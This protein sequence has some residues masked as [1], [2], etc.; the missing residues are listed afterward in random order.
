MSDPINKT[1]E[2]IEAISLEVVTI[3]GADISAM[4]KILNLLCDMEEDAE[5]IG[6]PVFSDLIYGLKN[7]LEKAIMGETDDFE[8]FELGVEHLGSIHRCIRNQEKYKDDISDILDKL[9]FKCS[10][11]EQEEKCSQQDRPKFESDTED[12]NVSAEES[13]AE[14]N[15]KIEI[16]EDIKHPDQDMDEEDREILSGFVMESLE[17]LEAVEVSMMDLEQDPGDIETI[18]SIFR[19]FHTIKGVSAFL[20][21]DRINMLAHRSENLLDKARSSEIRID[22]TVIDI[23]LESVDL[24]KKLIEGVQQGM[25]NGVSLDIGLDITSLVDRIEKIQVEADQ[26]ADKPLGEILI[27]KGE[28]TPEELANALES[29]K[30]EPVKKIGQIL[31]QEKSVDPKSVVAALRNQK[32]TGK[33]HID[34][35]VKVDTK[36]LDNLVDLTGELVIAQSMLRQNRTILATRDQQLM[37]NLGQ[38]TQ[39]TTGLQTTAMSM[40]MVPIKNTFQKMV[41][42]VRDLAKN[43]GKEVNLKMSGKDTEIDRNVVDELYEPMVHMIRNSVDHGIETP[44]ERKKAGKDKSGEIHLMAYHQGGNIVVEISDDGR[45]LGK[46]RIIEKAKVNNLITDESKISESEIYNLIFHP[47][48]STAKQVTNV[49]GRGVGMDVVKKAIEKLRGKVEINSSPGR[50][51]TFII[52]LPLT[53]AIIEG[54]LVRVGQEKY[55]IPALSILESLRPTKEQ[56]STVEGKGEMILTRGKLIPLIRLNRIFDA[57]CDHNNPWEAL[58][59]VVEQNGNQIGLLL[60]ELLGK[61]EVVIKSLG[62]TL[63]DIKGIAGG[64][65]MGDGRVGLILDMAGIWDLTMGVEN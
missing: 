51:S 43:S 42:L 19:A 47:G 64:A 65:I 10:D 22:A 7:Y 63:K 25:E 34:L 24:L 33:R 16:K 28:I 41:R 12:E 30:K 8:P 48:F 21:L 3:D 27:Q 40:R 2:K 54:M 11:S 53:L 5:K 13:A 14:P 6:R 49:S 32:K 58:I 15:D 18:N 1:K 57:E 60:D 29:Q 55:V 31:V 37:N 61:E 4:G 38:L 26:I 52:K 36:K 17:S 59:M 45:G 46:E 44:E 9:G 35:Q 39:I 20:D 62:E 50:G 56:Y 23:C